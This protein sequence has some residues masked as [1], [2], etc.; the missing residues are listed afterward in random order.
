[1]GRL[2]AAIESKPG[3]GLVEVKI[4][5]KQ[6][7]GHRGAASLVGKLEAAVAE[8]EDSGFFQVV[9]V[10]HFPQKRDEPFLDSGSAR[11]EVGAL[12]TLGIQIV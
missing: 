3:I 10:E 8:G 4:V 6:Q 7:H 11:I 12:T 1:M 5:G 9:K 2:P